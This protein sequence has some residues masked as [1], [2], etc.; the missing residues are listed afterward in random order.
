M[1]A[2]WLGEV[3][4]QRCLSCGRAGAA[5]CSACGSSFR[6][7]PVGPVPS[8]VNRLWCP[9]SYEGPARSLILGLKLRGLR[10][11][12]LPLAEGMA[13][14]ARSG[15]IA[16][17]GVAWVPGRRADIRVRGFDHAELLARAL[18]RR[19][20]L[21]PAPLLRRLHTG[22]DQTSLSAPER[23]R[24]VK[25][26]FAASGSPRQVILV[27]DLVTTG[28]TAAASAAALRTAGA[29]RVELVVPARA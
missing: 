12:A 2:T 14:V 22:P 8:G 15:G 24:N 7:P 20:G 1:G 29:T 3:V 23:A 6:P 18:A 25:G 4:G 28:A 13:E 5:L 11:A 19:L 27:D 16:A 10:A 17:T 26:A 21:S 9:W